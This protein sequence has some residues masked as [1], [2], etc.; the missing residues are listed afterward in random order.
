[1]TFILDRS[2]T[3]NKNRTMISSKPLRAILIGL[4]VIAA[5]AAAD[6]SYITHCAQCHGTDGAGNDEIG[7]PNLTLL[8]EPYIERQLHAFKTGWRSAD[9]RY[10]QSMVAAIVTLDA[11]VLAKATTAISALPDKNV[12]VPA[13]RLGDKAR[14][15]TLYTAYCG[16]C[17]GT[18]ALGNDA[19]GAPNLLGL[20]GD[21]LV[22]QYLNFAEGR[23]GTHTN[24]R[25][26]QQMARLAKA[27]KDPKLI[28]DV[29]A[30]VVS[31]AE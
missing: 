24:D 3:K 19:L 16:A 11:P 20:S 21:Y 22:R 29:T 25:Y 26:G 2:N 10:T 14:G 31:I 18:T 23:R 5:S 15:K 1:M 6:N 28:D 30:Y 27:L 9:N 4:V 17:H 7:A 12:A 13:A 8:S